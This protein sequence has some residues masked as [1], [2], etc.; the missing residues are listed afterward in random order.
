[1][2]KS[3]YKNKALSRRSWEFTLSVSKV[4]YRPARLKTH[5][6]DGKELRK[7]KKKKP[8]KNAASLHTHLKHTTPPATSHTW[9]MFRC[10][11]PLGL[12]LALL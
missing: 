3:T 10:S 7:K 1:M 6:K 8:H 9:T 5:T 11:S 12:L 2:I 4:K